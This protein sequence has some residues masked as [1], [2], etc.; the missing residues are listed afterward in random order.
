MLW[1][2]LV[3]GYLLTWGVIPHLLLAKKRP[4]ATVAW[5]WAILLFPYLGASAYVLLGSERM[6][7]R[8]RRRA[9]KMN[10]ARHGETPGASEKIARQTPGAAALLRALATINEIPPSTATDLR[11]LIDACAF[12][13]A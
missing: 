3:I 6:T 9:K 8:R 4:A 5:V 12:Y 2:A 11:L 13:P 1:T 7:R 10:L